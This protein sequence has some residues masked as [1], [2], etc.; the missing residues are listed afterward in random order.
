M[1]EQVG[2]DDPVEIVRHEEQ[3]VTGTEVRAVGDVRFRKEVD[4]VN[5][6]V[7]VGRG[8]EHADVERLPA[9]E[10][11]TDSGLVET[12]PDGSISI[13]VFEERL[14]I[15]KRLVVRER[16][17]V[18]KHTVTEERV[19]DAELRRERVEIDVDESVRDSVQVDP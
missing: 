16:I 8:V 15:E 18:R 1:S 7:V 5:E 11:G 14:V 9:T 19:V 6:Q 10:G 17:V 3:L 2:T 13:P 4:V 12:L